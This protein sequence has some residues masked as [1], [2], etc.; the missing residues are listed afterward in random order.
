MKTKTEK[1]NTEETGEKHTELQDGVTNK[2]E[3]EKKEGVTESTENI[4]LEQPAGEEAKTEGK[5][6]IHDPPSG[7]VIVV[8]PENESGTDDETGNKSSSPP[9]LP[10]R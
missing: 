8:K 10:P 3:E 6:D 4:E 9:A 7:S 1:G 2:D 5:C